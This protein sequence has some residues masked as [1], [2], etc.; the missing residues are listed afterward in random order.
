MNVLD[1]SIIKFF[2]VV[3][4]NA[5]F[6][7]GAM[8]LVSGN[9]LIKGGFIVAV[10]WYIWFNKKHSSPDARRKV[11]LTIYAC[12]FA[13]I[14]GRSLAILLPYR[15]RPILN[16]NFNFT[17]QINSFSW[18]NTWSSFPS[19]H[20]VLFFSLAMGIFLISRKLGI[21]SLVYVLIFV[22]LPRVYLGFHYPSDILV[23]A[24]VGIFITWITFK[25]KPFQSLST[26][27]L[28]LS[29]RYPGLSYSLLFLLTFQIACM[30]NDS[31]SIASYIVHSIQNV[32]H[33]FF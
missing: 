20:A 18:L 31:R 11:V 4:H 16:P 8:F 6:L 3:A 14:V 27:T 33:L 19:D 9:N 21:I 24:V 25:L 10:L 5:T 2:N 32:F 22:A 17:F 23:G 28:A 12:F 15:A 7:N 29:D 1:D 30:F 13:I 26:K